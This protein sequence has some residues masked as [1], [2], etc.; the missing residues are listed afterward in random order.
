MKLA[1]GE[2]ECTGL[3]NLLGDVHLVDGEGDGRITLGWKAQYPVLLVAVVLKVLEHKEF[4][5][6]ALIT[7]SDTHSLTA[8]T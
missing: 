8:A 6:T 1:G 2:E 7:S 5:G 4:A 3:Q